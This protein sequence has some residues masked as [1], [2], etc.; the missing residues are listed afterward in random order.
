MGLN[1]NCNFNGAR[2]NSIPPIPTDV[3]LT[4]T[5]DTTISVAY[6]ST[7][8]VEI[9]YS[10]TELGT[11]TKHGDS[12]SSPYPMTGLTQGILYWIK[13]RA[14]NGSKYSAFGSAV[15]A[16]TKPTGYDY[17][18]DFNDEIL[19]DNNNEIIYNLN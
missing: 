2:K 17:L 4:V 8:P 3:V 6:V 9:W 5:N 19:T 10:T 11:Y 14:K 12:S 18:I 1:L 7:K 15:S 13:I 16:E